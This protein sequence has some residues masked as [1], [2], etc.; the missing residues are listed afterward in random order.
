VLE[1]PVPYSVRFGGQSKVAGSLGG[2]VKA[3][4]SIISTLARVLRAPA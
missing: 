3:T 1:I 2:T 4:V